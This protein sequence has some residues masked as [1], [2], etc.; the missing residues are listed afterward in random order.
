[1][2][3]VLPLAPFSF[4]YRLSKEIFDLTINAAQFVLRPG[5]Q[6]GQELRVDTKQKRLSVH[7]PFRSVVQRASIQH[8]MGF[9]LTAEHDHKLA[10]LIH[11]D[12][13]LGRS[14]EPTTTT[15]MTQPF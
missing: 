7:Q 6:F 1:V 13:C 11:H 8:W 10:D 12:G 4:L 15:S 2:R 3:I 14:S 9:G 5:F